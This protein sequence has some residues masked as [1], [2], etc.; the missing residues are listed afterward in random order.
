MSLDV[1]LAHDHAA[2]VQFCK[3]ENAVQMRNAIKEVGPDAVDKLGNGSVKDLQIHL[4]KNSASAR[5]LFASTG[6]I[7]PPAG[8]QLQESA[9]QMLKRQQKVAA[10]VEHHIARET[11][12]LQM[13]IRTEAKERRRLQ[14]ELKHLRT[15]ERMRRQA[16]IQVKGAT[17]FDPD[18]DFVPKPLPP[19]TKRAVLSV[20]QRA[21]GLT[22]F[23]M[24]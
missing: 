6:E 22:F 20:D 13:Q 18:P 1:Q 8:R 12:D 15:A 19:C 4:L 10:A 5:K 14:G 23:E 17:R 11:E 3:K 7:A 16:P 21:T 2:W 9:S 24:G